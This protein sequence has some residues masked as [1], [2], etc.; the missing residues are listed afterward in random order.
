M[1]KLARAGYSVCVVEETKIVRKHGSTSQFRDREAVAL[2][3]PA[4]YHLFIPDD[5]DGDGPLDH[6]QCL[7][8]VTNKEN[9]YSTASGPAQKLS[10][11]PNEDS[12]DFTGKMKG[13]LG[14]CI[15]D[16]TVGQ[17]AVSHSTKSSLIHDI[18]RMNPSEILLC[19]RTADEIPDVVE[20]LKGLFNV[21]LSDHVLCDDDGES[22]S[23]SSSL[24]YDEIVEHIEW[25]KHLFVCCDANGSND[26]VEQLLADFG[27]GLETKLQFAATVLLLQYLRECRVPITS[28][29]V[30][31]LNR[32]EKKDVL[33]MDYSTR[34]ALE[35]SHS[36]HD[37]NHVK[38]LM[39][40]LNVCCT[41]SGRRL[42]KQRLHSP[43]TDIAEIEK[44]LDFIA[45]FRDNAT[46]REL[47]VERL[48]SLGDFQKLYQG[49][50]LQSKLCDLEQVRLLAVD[51]TS[52]EDIFEMIQC[53]TIDD[54]EYMERTLMPHIA[55]SVQRLQLWAERVR[56]TN[57]NEER[58][59]LQR[60]IRENNISSDKALSIKKTLCELTGTDRI[61][62]DSLEMYGFTLCI[63]PMHCGNDAVSFAEK[64]HLQLISSSKSLYRFKSAA[65][66][67]MQIEYQQYKQLLLDVD[68]RTVQRHIGELHGISGDLYDVGMALCEMDIAASVARMRCVLLIFFNFKL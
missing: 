43:I 57:H 7:V 48:K 53:H 33:F 40:T 56:S 49:I 18:S 41:P 42:L 29:L 62:L 61:K 2:L 32:Y 9:A 50:L 64:H 6:N 17:M 55:E 3:S 52:I 21:T 27:D 54:V 23:I 37:H 46:A 36:L 47:V 34:R 31:S 24:E 59:S 63:P 12:L 14:L 20:K 35:I 51:I 58:S 60:A 38:S 11:N 16:T 45:F 25:D 5:V 22:E 4:T 28:D 19:S 66:S 44:R 8:A 13:Y 65:L 26:A 10:K 15:M 39:H 30:H 1:P 68:K 67:A